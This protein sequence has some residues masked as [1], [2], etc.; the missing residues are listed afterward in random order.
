M[1]GNAPSVGAGHAP[2]VA[3]GTG[4]PLS[5]AGLIPGMLPPGMMQGMPA[6]V[7]GTPLSVWVGNAP[8]VQALAAS[9][10][11]RVLAP[12]AGETPSAAEISGVVWETVAPETRALIKRLAGEALLAGSGAGSAEVVVALACLEI[13]ARRWP[14]L[15][16]A[17]VESCGGC[18]SRPSPRRLT[19][20]VII[21][22]GAGI[23]STACLSGASRRSWRPSGA[24]AV[25]STPNTCRRW[26][27]GSSASWPVGWSRATQK[28]ASPRARRS[29]TPATFTKPIRWPVPHVGF[30]Y[31]SV[32]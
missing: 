27:A 7:A 14:E 19:A 9:H 5:V 28:S 11:S 31:R 20:V 23:G 32:P 13:P 6:V 22:P 24:S 26:P 2:S 15:V 4:S 21:P 1:V 10:F 3:V 30:S 29:A 8:A 12:A 17:L 16:P 25:A 18:L